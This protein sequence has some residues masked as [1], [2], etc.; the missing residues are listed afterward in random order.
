MSRAIHTIIAIS[1]FT[2]TVVLA[3]KPVKCPTF[4]DRAYY[5]VSSRDGRTYGNH[6]MLEI[7][8]C[9]KNTEALVDLHFVI[10]K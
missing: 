6:C 7:A 1:I 9:D 3:A 4:C 5:P 2:S 8:L 10:V